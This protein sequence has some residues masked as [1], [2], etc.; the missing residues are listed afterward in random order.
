[1]LFTSVPA[2]FI[3]FIIGLA[4]FVVLCF[5]KVPRIISVLIAALIMALGTVDVP[6]LTSMFTN[7]LTGAM[8]VVKVYLAPGLA[9]VVAGCALGSTGCATKI[10]RTVMNAIG[11]NK[12]CLV[13]MIVSALVALSGVMGDFIVIPLVLAVCRECK[14]SRG[15]GLLCFVSQVQIIQFNLVGV[16]AVPQLIIAQWLGITIYESVAMS[17]VCVIIAEL[18]VYG[19]AMLFVHSDRKKGVGFNE[20]PEIDLLKIPDEQDDAELPSFLFSLIP[21]VIIIGGSMVLNL[22]CKLD[23]TAAAVISQI[24]AIIFLVITR[25]KH[26]HFSGKAHTIMEEFGE[27]INMVL[28]VIIVIGFVGGLGSVISTMAWYN[29]GIQWALSLNASPY[30]LCFLVVALIVLITSDA[31]AGI[32]MFMSTLGPQFMALP[33][34]SLPALHRIISATACS[35]DSMPW[36]AG[37]Y[38]YCVYHGMSVKTGW[39]YYTIATVGITTFMALFYVVWASIAWPC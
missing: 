4:V 26:W 21:L 32:S 17:V 9:G 12:G 39:K 2:S 23:I 30:L 19:I 13:I 8:N 10:A 34:I 5:T 29:P 6:V 11:R 16:P 18:L 27:N 1:M 20:T 31:I 38:R 24:V 28:P 15:V 33:G 36:T 7:L 14:L 35:L 37:C 3:C 22:V 25:R